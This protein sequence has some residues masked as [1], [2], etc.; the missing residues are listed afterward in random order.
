MQKEAN[1]DQELVFKKRA[2]RRLVGAVALVLLMI[3]VLPMILKERTFVQP[4]EEITI[5]LPN[6]SLSAN[7]TPNSKNDS[8]ITQEKSKDDFDSNIDDAN[9]VDIQIPLE[10][11]KNDSQ[12]KNNLDV[13]NNDDLQALTDKSAAL[14][15][16]KTTKKTIDKKNPDLENKVELKPDATSHFYVQVGVFSDVENVKQLQAKLNDI[17]YKSQT[18]KINTDKGVKIRLRTQ[19]FDSRFDAATALENI[20]EAGLTGMVVSKTGA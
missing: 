19:S 10:T 9:Q 16:D 3:I 4:K 12:A 6:E 14:K 7:T 8:I 1:N 20:K 5:T 2:R 11:L 18:E 15:T 17:G 13:N